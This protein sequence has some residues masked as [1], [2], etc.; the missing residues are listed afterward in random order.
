MFTDTQLML[1]PGLR[2]KSGVALGALLALGLL[3]GCSSSG[4]AETP[5]SA[6]SEAAAGETSVEEGEPADE[7]RVDVPTGLEGRSF[8]EGIDDAEVLAWVEAGI[9]EMS[10]PPTS[11]L[12]LI[13]PIGQEVDEEPDPQLFDGDMF[14]EHTQ[15]M[16]DED[17]QATVATFTT[18][19]ENLVCAED[20][21]ERELADGAERVE[22]WIVHGADVATAPD[23][24]QK[25][26]S[27][28]YAWP[29]GVEETT[30]KQV[31]FH[32]AYHGF[33][34]YLINQCSQAEGKPE[35]TYE[36]I[37][38]FAEGT[39]EYFGKYM[40]AK[41][42]GRDDYLQTILGNAYEDY[43][44]SGETDFRNAYYQAA[45]VALMI[46]RGSLEASKV[47]DGSYFHDCV[48]METYHPDQPEPQYIAN[49][50]Y[51]IEKVGGVYRFTDEA[52]AG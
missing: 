27:A 3:A 22:R 28:V 1:L 40:A 32:E 51:H 6:E 17:L 24:C 5:V 46:E 45:G 47:K 29:Q 11:F 4:P 2:N 39:A 19:Q 42:D 12:G 50:F 23:P 36:G 35:E 15:A 41:I 48:Y 49:N 37:R 13:W 33:S 52:V 16:S 43:R 30:A 7:A 25:A 31:F 10:Q 38:W 26:R 14:R 34:N 9:A 20:K 18:W 8:V 21:D 44:G